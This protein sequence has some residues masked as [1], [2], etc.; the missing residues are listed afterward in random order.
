VI[1]LL[2]KDIGPVVDWNTD[3][4]SVFSDDPARW[5]SNAVTAPT[6]PAPPRSGSSA[7]ANS[8]GTRRP[9]RSR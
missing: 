9:A 5:Q 6:P 1:S 7:A 2:H 3:P 4:R 8:A